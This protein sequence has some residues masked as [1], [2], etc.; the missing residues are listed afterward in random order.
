[1]SKKND[2]D[3]AH[4]NFNAQQAIMVIFGSDVAERVSYPMVI[5]Y[6]T[7]P[8]NVSAPPA[9]TWILKIVFSVML[10]TISQ[11]WHCF[12]LLYLPHSS[13]NFDNFSADNKVVE[14]QCANIISRLAT[15]A[16]DQ[17]VNKINVSNCA[18]AASS[19]SA[20]TTVHW[21]SNSQLL[22]QLEHTAFQPLP[23]TL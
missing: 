20:G 13:I 7:S 18:G 16:Q 6:P 15:F 21:A 19:A 22:Q 8:T 4:Y 3:V 17:I 1:V 14:V 11:K 10:Y 12:G 23:E 2:T 5:W 9:E